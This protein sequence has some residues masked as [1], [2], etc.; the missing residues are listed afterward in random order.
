MSTTPQLTEPGAQTDIFELYE[1]ARDVDADISAVRPVLRVSVFS[2]NSGF[3]YDDEAVIHRLM[4]AD[5]CST[6]DKEALAVASVGIHPDHP[7]FDL[8][9]AMR[10]QVER[11]GTAT[12]GVRL[13]LWGATVDAGPA[14]FREASEL[15]RCREV[16]EEL[17]RRPAVYEGLSIESL[18][19]EWAKASGVKHQAT[20]KAIPRL[21][22]DVL[23]N[24]RPADLYVPLDFSACAFANSVASN[25]TVAYLLF[26]C[27]QRALA[28]EY[29]GEVRWRS[30]WLQGESACPEAIPGASGPAVRRELNRLLHERVLERIE[31]WSGGRKAATYR[32]RVAVQRGEVD[33][34]QAATYLGVKLDSRL[35]PTKAPRRR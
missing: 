7:L 8:R 18:V 13:L 29:E 15:I 17:D 27:M 6:A 25:G 5:L 2:H 12:S 26:R 11:G 9:E 20:L 16:W 22:R 30:K 10:E 19:V 21:C 33:A 3:A 35:A 14:L 24:Q 32:F 31:G 23:L 34:A 4:T 1:H 28:F